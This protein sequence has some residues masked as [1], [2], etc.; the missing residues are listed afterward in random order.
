MNGH[1]F[2][3]IDVITEARQFIYRED[4]QGIKDK[5]GNVLEV[6]KSLLRTALAVPG[7][8]Q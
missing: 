5:Y 8:R 1:D 6:I 2:E 7:D 3:E 4:Y